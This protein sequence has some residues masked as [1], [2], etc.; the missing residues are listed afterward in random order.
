MAVVY[1]YQDFSEMK[2]IEVLKGGLHDEKWPQ[3][4]LKD[5]KYTF[6]K[7][8]ESWQVPTQ[9]MLSAQ[10]YSSRTLL[11]FI[12]GSK[13]QLGRAFLRYKRGR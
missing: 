10:P 6:E 5:Q 9:N 7:A 11:D 4:V 13:R 3:N 12:G 8:A 1:E 2:K